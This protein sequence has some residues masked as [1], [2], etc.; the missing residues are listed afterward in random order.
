MLDAATTLRVRA[1]DSLRRR[2][3]HVQWAPVAALAVVGLAW[4]VVLLW[5][6]SGQWF[7]LDATHYITQRGIIPGRSVGL[8]APWGGHFVLGPIIAYRIVFTFF[9]MKTIIPYILMAIVAHLGV[10]CLARWTLREVGL[11]PWL[12]SFVAGVLLFAG[13]GAEAIIW[14]AAMPLMLPLGFT[15]ASVL[16]LLRLDFSERAIRVTQVLLTLGMVFSGST[17]TAMALV[18]VFIVFNRGLRPA[19]RAIAPGVVL[20]VA[21]FMFIGHTANRAGLD[22]WNTFRVPEFIW[23]ALTSPLEKATGIPGSGAVLLLGLVAAALLVRDVPVHLRQLSWAGLAAALTN[24]ALTAFVNIGFGIGAADASRYAY[25]VMFTLLPTIALVAYW[26]VHTVSTGLTGDRRV[27]LAAIGV[28]VSLMY[29]ATG[30]YLLHQTASFSH[31]TGNAWK[32]YAFGTIAAADDGEKVLTPRIVA[33]NVPNDP[34]DYL[35]PQIRK[36]LPDTKGTPQQRIDAEGLF[37]TDLRGTSYDL[38]APEGGRFEDGYIGDFHENKTCSPYDALGNEATLVV[39]TGDSDGAQVRIKGPATA[40]QTQLRRDQRFTD[41]RGW[42]VLA[43]ADVYVATTAKDA[44]LAITVNE[45]GRYEI[46]MP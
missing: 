37:F 43:G 14:D 15:L 39:K 42:P 22:G 32:M 18:A 44:E 20:F 46:C 1:T 2:T 5:Q 25:V 4:F 6:G 26:L 29:V 41:Q 12:A 31:G 30:T 16:V 8:F 36:A 3:T 45:P 13:V 38:P 27:V 19:V 23:T 33:L 34:R 40:I 17:F 7:T 9:G 10:V 28:P 24:A 11:G 21:W 35:T